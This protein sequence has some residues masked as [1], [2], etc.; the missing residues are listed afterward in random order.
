[1]NR[2]RLIS[3]ILLLILIL[4]ISV[5]ASASG[6]AGSA[7][8]PLISKSYIDNTYPGLVLTDPLNA[9]AD[10]MTFL[11]YK[12]TQASQS[13]A[14]AVNTVLAMPGGT[15]SL[16]AGSGFVLVFGSVKLASGSGTVIDLTDGSERALGK[17][18]SAG[19]RYVAAENTTIT[20]SVITASKF[21]VFGSVTVNSGAAPK[22]TDVPDSQW[23]FSDVCYAV[24]KG[25][26]NGRSETA[27]APD[28]YLSVAEAIKLAACMNQLYSTGSVTLVNDT[29]DP[30]KWYK[31]YLDYA[32]K[33]G[34]VTKTYQDYDANI[35][36]SEFVA[37]FYAALP[38]TE[39]TQINTVSD[40]KIP[41]VKLTAGN[42][43]QIYAFYRAGILIGSE[44]G[45]FYPINNIKRSEVAAI[46][47]RMFEKDARK[48]ITLS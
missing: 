27:Y 8:D 30:K 21:S 24:Q 26:V 11:N 3:F 7:N 37:I 46:L 12:L 6:I 10:T 43:K 36:R 18:L 39:Y 23:Y 47:T 22:F 20:A 40:N 17:T 29:T 15:V 41:D 9:L 5:P 14:S 28:E 16:S 25:L 42:A 31:T 19:H 44:N 13:K 38:E 45:N 2:K 48:S 35:S 33:N 4:S 34:I 32:T 1:M